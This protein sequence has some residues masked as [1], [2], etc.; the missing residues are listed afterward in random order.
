MCFFWSVCG[1]HGGSDDKIWEWYRVLGVVLML[2]GIG[3]WCVRLCSGCCGLVEAAAIIC[4][5]LM[6]RWSLTLRTLVSWCRWSVGVVDVQPVMIFRAL[7]C[8]VCSV[9]W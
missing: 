5:P 8:S 9:L 1:G 4:V 7:F 2:L 6:S 3:G